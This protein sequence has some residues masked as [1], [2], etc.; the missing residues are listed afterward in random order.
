MEYIDSYLSNEA[1]FDRTGLHKNRTDLHKNRTSLYKKHLCIHAENTA[2]IL[3][4]PIHLHKGIIYVFFI[5]LCH[6]L[7]YTILMGIYI[8]F[9]N[10]LYTFNNVTNIWFWNDKWPVNER[11]NS[12]ICEK[13]K[14]AKMWME[15]K[16]QT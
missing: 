16:A 14:P 6:S 15:R 9:I 2:G 13:R 1:Y 8:L 11:A 5:Y 7:I 4:D 10:V 3:Q 12:K